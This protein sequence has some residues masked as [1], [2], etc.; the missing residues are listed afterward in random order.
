[1][2]DWACGRFTS[3]LL[4][5]T[6]TLTFFLNDVISIS[7]HKSVLLP[8]NDNSSEHKFSVALLSLCQ[9]G[10]LELAASVKSNIG[11]KEVQ[12]ASKQRSWL[13]RVGNRFSYILKCRWRTGDGDTVTHQRTHKHA[14]A[15]R[16]TDTHTYRHIFHQNLNEHNT[17][18]LNSKPTSIYFIIQKHAH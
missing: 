16:H 1:M 4:T 6:T 14:H 13:L 11:W 3:N 18:R 12:L 17:L 9:N 8:L 7:P 15:K 5:T 2:S 10:Q